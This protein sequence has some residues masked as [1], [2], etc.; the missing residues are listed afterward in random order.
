MPL[1]RRRFVKGLSAALAAAGCRPRGTASSA[2]LSSQNGGEVDEFDYIVVGSGAGGGPVA[3]NLAKAGYQVL[4]LEAGGDEGNREVYQIPAM[5]PASTE[6]EN[7]AWDFFVKHF[8]DDAKGKNDPKFVEGKGI[9]YPRAGTLGGC[10]AHNAMI[11]IYPLAKDWDDMASTVGDSSYNSRTMRRYFSLVEN[12][13]YLKD[14]ARK[15]GWLPISFASPTL[16]IGDRQILTMTVAACSA[17][18]KAPFKAFRTIKSLYDLVRLADTNAD[19]LARDTAE[20]AVLVPLSTTRMGRRFS[21]RDLLKTQ[22]GKGLTIK[23]GCLVTKVVFAEAPD[24]QGNLVA[25][26]V[27]YLAGQRIYKASKSPGQVQGPARRVKALRE[28]I[29]AAGAFNTP[30]L[31]M[32]SGLGPRAELEPLATA[33]PGFRVL[34]DLPGVGKNLQDR[35]EV[36][37]VNMTS[38]YMSLIEKCK[39]QVNVADPC[40]AS[41][42]KGNGPFVSNGAVLALKKKSRPELPHPDLFIFLLPNQFTGYFDRYAERGYELKNRMTWAILKSHAQSIRGEVR[43]KTL[44]PTDT[45]DINFRYFDGEGAKTDLD[46]LVTAVE[47]VRKIGDAADQFYDASDLNFQDLVE[48]STGRMRNYNEIFP[49]KTVKT[50]AQIQE[51]VENTT[52]GH[53]ASCSCKMGT[54]ADELAVVDSR[55]KVRGT[56]NLRIVDASVFPRIPGYFI[57]S[58]IYALSEKA[59]DDILQDQGHRRRV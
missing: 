15:K 17:I 22:E 27:E 58:S 19:T 16:I 49:G 31:M 13:N 55:F 51:W 28:V 11:T 42:K 44:D 39:F 25:E 43:L 36:G 26:G 21:T 48:T 35:Y 8:D 52:W 38:N 7:M 59:S 6:D 33:N 46:A 9:L 18:A 47:F 5:H 30:Q 54:E 10:T 45:P 14:P 20:G 12:A 4:V 34:K 29:L 24:A 2:A 41:W 23:T 53:H 50:R 32:L 37:V 56:A 1:H 40:Y 57:M 3:V